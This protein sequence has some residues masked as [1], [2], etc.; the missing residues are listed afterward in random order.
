MRRALA[1]TL[2]VAACGACVRP[3]AGGPVRVVEIVIHHSRFQPAVVEVTAGETVR[4]V[5]RNT[6]PIDHEVIVGDAATQDR[7]ELGTEA[8]HGEVPGEASVAAG[9]TAS[10]SYTFGGP[11]AVLMGCHLPGHY[12]YGMRGLIRVV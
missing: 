3:P 12:D 9:Q 1:T 8:K 7:H 5:V 6:D 4:F 2:I 11:G 10:T